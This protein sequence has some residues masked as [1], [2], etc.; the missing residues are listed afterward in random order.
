MSDDTPTQRF[1]APLT[2]STPPNPDPHEEQRRRTR[3]LMYA[4]I[5]VGAA[6]LVAL[7][8]VLIVLFTRDST[9]T[10]ASTPT[11]STTSSASATAS[12][13]PTPSSTPTAAAPATTTAP[14]PA[15]APTANGAPVFTSFTIPNATCTGTT[16]T[17]PVTI[18]YSS[19]GATAAYFG[20][21][22]ANA[23]EAP[24]DGP[25]PPNGPYTFDYQCS[26]ATQIWV[27][28]LVDGAG[29]TT[30]KSRE[31]GSGAK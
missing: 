16:G 17:S 22:V 25:L 9:P 4:L 30:N 29:G 20:I 3:G 10:A 14:K 21:G 23:K 26:N 28:T 15:P 24:T 11:S 12:E 5:A 1:D 7:I 27:I 19:V 6:V 8:V 2:P 18:Q 13:S 31:V